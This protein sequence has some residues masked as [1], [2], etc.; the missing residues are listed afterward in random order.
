MPS[1]PL[2]RHALAPAAAAVATLLVACNAP[3]TRR[4]APAQRVVADERP[5]GAAIEDDGARDA[6]APD[7]LRLSRVS[8]PAILDGDAIEWNALHRAMVEAAGALALEEQVL[9]RL[10]EA[11][12]RRR[13]VVVASA[14]LQREELALEASLGD[15]AALPAERRR[16]VEEIRRRRGLGTDRY[17]ALLRRTALLRA[18]VRPRVEITPEQLDLAM[19]IR[20]GEKR[21]VRVIAVSTLTE[22]Q[23]VLTRLDRG[24][25][26]QEVA[27]QWSSDPSAARGG[28]IEPFSLADPSY[29]GA[30]RDA[31]AELSPGEV[32]G[33][34]ALPSGFAIIRLEE[35]IPGDD[36]ELSTVR[37]IVL[38]DAR[39]EQER[40]LMTQLARRLLAEANLRILDPTLESAWRR[41]RAQ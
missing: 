14:D 16:L 3:E 35:I 23:A 15:V 39:L 37:P 32:S 29:P 22:A 12:A 40:V 10:L 5:A 13:G 26:F 9:D 6:P 1:S 28:L 25:A 34:I 33:A 17:E 41:R 38:E 21:R 24:E 27:A 7:P 11:E 31:A 4:P 36:V 30:F 18:L 20:F 2:P 19:T 8:P